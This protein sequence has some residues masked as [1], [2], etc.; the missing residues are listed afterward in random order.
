MASAKPNSPAPSS[1]AARPPVAEDH[2]GEAHEAS[3][4]GL[5]VLELVGEDVDQHDAAEPGQRAR[6]VTP[7]YFIVYTG[8]PSDSAADR[9]LADRAQPQTERGA[10][11][12][13]GRSR[14]QQRCAMT[15]EQRHVG[16]EARSTPADVREE[17]P[18]S[19]LARASCIAADSPARQSGHVDVRR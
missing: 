13:V 3:A 7:M 12:H 5:P 6:D 8:T 2:G 14:E 16:G 17:E 19:L 10:P 4:V 15:I 1:D 11:Q 18:V 9:V